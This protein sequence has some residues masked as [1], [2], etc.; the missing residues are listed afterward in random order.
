MLGPNSRHAPVLFAGSERPVSCGEV[1]QPCGGR[2][3]QSWRQN[4]PAAS[5][6]VLTVS[7]H[8][9]SHIA[10]REQRAGVSMPCT[11]L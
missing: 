4:A 1:G 10:G 11:A 7:T 5:T 6:A 3:A 8:R 9:G 2:Q